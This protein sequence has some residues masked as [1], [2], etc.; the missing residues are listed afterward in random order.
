V[1]PID[2]IRRL[3]ALGCHLIADGETLRVQDPAQA[4]TVEWRA[5]IREHKG[6]MLPLLRDHPSLGVPQPSCKELHEPSWSQNSPVSQNMAHQVYS[7]NRA[8]SA[9][10]KADHVTC[11]SSVASDLKPHHSRKPVRVAHQKIWFDWDIPDGTYSPEQLRKAPI[12]VK[13][14][15][16]LQQYMLTEDSLHV[17]YRCRHNEG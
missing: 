16:P 1:S 14:W 4:L 9:N 13:P 12:I 6:G 11:H 3:T 15:R 2:L 8:N 17:S 7:A 10:Q 5:L